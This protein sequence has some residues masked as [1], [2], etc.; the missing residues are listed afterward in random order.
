MTELLGLLHL[1]V[2][3]ERFVSF[4]I[5]VLCKS[6]IKTKKER[7]TDKSEENIRFIVKKIK[8]MRTAKHLEA[9]NVALKEMKLGEKIN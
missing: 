9:E 2:E 7:N 6:I 8:I 5:F 4:E 3:L 1:L